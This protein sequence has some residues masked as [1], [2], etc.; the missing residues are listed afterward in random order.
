MSHLAIAAALAKD[1]VAEQF[2]DRRR[3]RRLTTNERSDRK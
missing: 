2:A 1:R 3:R